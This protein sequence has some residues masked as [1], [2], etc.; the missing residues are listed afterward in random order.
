MTLT[1]SAQ[2]SNPSASE[3]FRFAGFG[4]PNGTYVPD[5]VFDLLMPRLSD[6]ELRV[7]LYI[8]RRT[9]GFKKGAD[10]IS[11]KQMV[12]G[13]TTKD[14]RVLDGGC[15]LSRPSVTKA[16]RGLAMKNI[17]K[18]TANYSPQRGNEATTYTLVFAD[19]SYPRQV[20]DE[21][22][23]N[24]VTRGGRNAVT[25]QETVKQETEKQGRFEHSNDLPRMKIVDNL[26]ITSYLD[27]LT[28]DISRE[29]SD[30]AHL[31]SNCKQARNIF[32]VLNL[33]EE[34]FVEQYVYQARQKTKHQAK[35]RNK[36]AYFFATLR[37]LCG[38][39]S[40]DEA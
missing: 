8:I 18:A 4:I 16:V 3:V 31:A 21:G 33:S 10:D 2:K 20:G 22:G 38:V 30:T 24:G 12:E 17:V 26:G 19:E 9:F 29:F 1:S 25:T 15:G 35:V 32:A 14:G 5:E 36:M 28:V 40:D 39:E 7:L 27:N 23:G 11:L 34:V 13:I 37:E 6:I